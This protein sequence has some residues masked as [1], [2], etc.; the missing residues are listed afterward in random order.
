MKKK[1]LIVLTNLSLLGV[2]D[3]LFLTWEKLTGF[4]PRCSEYFKCDTVL[5][6]RWSSIGSIP[7]SVLGIFFYSAVFILC[8]SLFLDKKNFI[9]STF[10]LSLDKVLSVLTI[11]G[12]LFSIT[13]I[14]IMGVILKAWCLYCL[15][16]A[17]NCSIIF[18]LNFVYQKNWSTDEN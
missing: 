8:V 5:T 12:I 10:T 2:A 11:V 7:T 4:L 15:F 3:S 16:S 1:L 6:S 17:V 14:F 9:V 18:I 13:F